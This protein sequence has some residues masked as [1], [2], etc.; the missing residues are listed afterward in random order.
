MQGQGRIADRMGEIEADR[1][2]VAP[3]AVRERPEIQA[4]SREVLH[5]RQQDQ[6][7]TRPKP[8][9]RGDQVLG[10]QLILAGARPHLEQ[11]L[12]RIE[13]VIEQLRD[14]R[15]TI[16]RKGALLDQDALARAARPKEA[17]HHQVQIHGQGV[18]RDDFTGARAGQ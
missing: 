5:A 3:C 17:D 11:M 7:E 16:R 13:A 10:A 9:D 12:G 4:L 1:G 2:A 14:D 15:V 18:H 8:L 6:R